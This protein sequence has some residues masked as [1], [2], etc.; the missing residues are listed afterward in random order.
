MTPASNSS[1]QRRETEVERTSPRR[2][3]APGFSKPYKQQ[4]H[5]PSAPDSTPR[6]STDSPCP[7]P[8]E[9]APRVST[10]PSLR[11]THKKTRIPLFWSSVSWFPGWRCPEPAP[12][13]GARGRAASCSRSVLQD[14]P[15]G[16]HHELPGLRSRL[17]VGHRSRVPQRP[18]GSAW[19]F[20]GRGT[21]GVK[22]ESPPGE[23]RPAPSWG[24]TDLGA[25]G[26]VRREERRDPP[27]SR[28][29]GVRLRP[30]PNLLHFFLLLPPPFPRRPPRS[31]VPGVGAGHCQQEKPNL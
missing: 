21:R 11:R 23:E 12:G 1:E 5:A 8:R 28:F 20:P 10:F 4:Q 16:K 17:P 26:R 6:S 18:H 25:A 9:P 7:P 31:R 27:R 19:C 13:S 30:R 29:S 24:G 15:R 14:H 2:S 3:K 22:C